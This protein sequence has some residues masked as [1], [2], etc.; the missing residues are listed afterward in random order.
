M[1]ECFTA[2]R[3]INPSKIIDGID[4]MAADLL[5]EKTVRTLSKS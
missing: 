4:L 5:L 3:I 1:S 2:L